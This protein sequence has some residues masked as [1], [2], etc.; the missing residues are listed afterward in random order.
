MMQTFRYNNTNQW[1]KYVDRDFVQLDQKAAVN[2]WDLQ[3][4]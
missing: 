3:D 4:S 1:L 2:P